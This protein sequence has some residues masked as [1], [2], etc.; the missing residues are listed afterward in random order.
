[1]R[2]TNGLIRGVGCRLA[3]GVGHGVVSDSFIISFF[4]P[5]G[6]APSQRCILLY[7]SGEP[8]TSKIRWITPPILFELD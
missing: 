6:K 2:S 5:F 4:D 8:M 1:M 7:K 3:T